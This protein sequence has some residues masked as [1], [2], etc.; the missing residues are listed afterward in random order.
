MQTLRLLL[1]QLYSQLQ[2]PNA[3]PFAVEVLANYVETHIND[4]AVDI[5]VVNPEI[6]Y[7]AIEEFIVSIKEGSYQLVGL[8]IP[9]GTYLTARTILEKIASIPQKPLVVLGHAIPSYAPELFLC[10]FP[11]TIVVRGWGEEALAGIIEHLRTGAPAINDISN[12]AY[13]DKQTGAIISTPIRYSALPVP[14]KRI[15]THEYFARI[16]TSRGCHYGLCTFCTRPP[17]PSRFWQ[18]LPVDQILQ[19][20]KSLK[21]AGINYF[22]FTDEDFIGNDLEGALKIAEE[23][24]KIGGMTFSISLRADNI[25]NPKIPANAPE[26]LLRSRAIGQLRK[27]G[28]SFMFIGLESLSDSQLKRYGKGIT[29][30]ASLDSIEIIKSHSIPLEVGFIL[31]DPFVTLEELTQIAATLRKNQLWENVGGL[32]LELRVQRASAFETWLRKK[33][34]LGNFDPDLLSYEWAYQHAD[35]AKVAN[36]CK[37]WESPFTNGRRLIKNLVRTDI[38]NQI[39]SYF[40]R[41]FRKLD[42]L[43]LEEIISCYGRKV[44]PAEVRELRK[45]FEI[46]RFTLSGALITGLTQNCYE[47]RDEVINLIDELRTYRSSTKQMIGNFNEPDGKSVIHFILNR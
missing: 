11:N 19:S 20:V 5:Q 9:Q 8:S 16:E 43:M 27:A 25:L 35:V 18:R 45:D 13:V 3:E 30:K 39:A 47:K 1:V 44:S 4:V 26:N 12:I 40:T 37:A 34:L 42:L 23:I 32:F 33:G 28:L 31:F 22:T 6:N 10:D 41:I 15:N 38:E 7:Q 46:K 2:P 21:D 14:A 29:A 17:G 36:A 24:E